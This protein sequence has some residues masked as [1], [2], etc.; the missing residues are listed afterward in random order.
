MV[1]YAG[2]EYILL[3]FPTM[4]H[5]LTKEYILEKAVTLAPDLFLC[6]CYLYL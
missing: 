5:W 2:V 3:K 6:Q 1:L 4:G